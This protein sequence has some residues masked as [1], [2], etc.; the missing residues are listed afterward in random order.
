MDRA[1]LLGLGSGGR[2]L[3]EAEVAT[4]GCVV[5]PSRQQTPSEPC[6]GDLGGIAPHAPPGG[7][8][9]TAL[10]CRARGWETGCCLVP[11]FIQLV[12]T[13]CSMVLATE[14][15]APAEEGRTVS[16]CKS[17]TVPGR[18]SLLGSRGAPQNPL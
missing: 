4:Q 1:S 10:G 12:F 3:L 14:T 17:A 8:E 7:E 9:G 5:E 15:L 16:G 2:C 13:V 6:G 11:S 18:V